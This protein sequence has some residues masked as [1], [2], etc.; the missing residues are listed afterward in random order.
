MEKKYRAIGN[1]LKLLRR[2]LSQTEMANQFSMPLRTYQY[3]E[4]GER[5][6]P[7]QLVREIAEKYG[8]SADWIL[9]AHKEWNK[10]QTGYAAEGIID[11]ET[12]CQ[13]FVDAQNLYNKWAKI[14]GLPREDQTVLEAIIEIMTSGEKS[15]I[16]ALTQNTYEFRDKVRDKIEKN[17]G[18]PVGR[19]GDGAVKGGN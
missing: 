11:D 3:Y 4:S 5:Q 1:R 9:S 13:A 18:A 8:V 17:K 15:T 7:V 12:Q 6:P 16:L 14:A 10:E 2:K 19:I